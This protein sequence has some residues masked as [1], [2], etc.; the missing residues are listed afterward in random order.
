RF[1]YNVYSKRSER[2]QAITQVQ[3]RLE[4]TPS[5]LVKLHG[6]DVYLIFVESYGRTVFDRPFFTA[7]TR[8]LFD[9]IE[10]ELVDRGFAIASGTITSPTYGGHSWLAHTTLATGVE[11]TDELE[12][13]LVSVSKPKTIARFFHDAGYHTILAQ[14]GTTREWPKGEFYQFDQKYYFWNF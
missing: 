13:E 1:I 3:S 14:P 2:M 11:T 4:R 8:E 7:R 12:Y 10:S 5:N 6:T 9:N